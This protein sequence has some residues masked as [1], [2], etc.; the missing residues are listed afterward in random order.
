MHP[1][2]HFLTYADLAQRYDKSRVTIWRWVRAG[3][4]P[5]PVQLGP[6]SVG[7]PVPDVLEFETK[8]P[9]VNYQPEEAA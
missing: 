3:L 1:H 9:R 7:F 2:Q 4:L 5:A 8:L 6:N